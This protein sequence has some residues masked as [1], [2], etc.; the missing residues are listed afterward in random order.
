MELNKQ[1][2]KIEFT[3]NDLSE[4]WSLLL[5]LNPQHQHLHVE[6]VSFSLSTF[7]S[8]TVMVTLRF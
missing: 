8:M 6:F 1:P 3:F 5:A 2:V 7:I 4:M